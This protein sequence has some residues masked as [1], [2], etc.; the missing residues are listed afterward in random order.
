MIL[1]LVLQYIFFF[2][3]I[4]IDFIWDPDS[5]VTKHEYG[6]KLRKYVRAAATFLGT[7]TMFVF[8]VIHKAASLPSRVFDAARGKGA[9][10]KYA[11]G[12]GCRISGCRRRCASQADALLRPVPHH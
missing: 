3:N 5:V 6:R 2:V 1:L 8:Y 9:R 11:P 12:V 10:A 4:Y 7:A